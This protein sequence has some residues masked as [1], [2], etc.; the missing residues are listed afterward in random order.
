[1]T[2]LIYNLTLTA[3]W[4]LLSVGAGIYDLAAGFITAGVVLIF[5]TIFNALVITK[6]WSR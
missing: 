5:L 2:P 6:R 3:G 1:M 4:L